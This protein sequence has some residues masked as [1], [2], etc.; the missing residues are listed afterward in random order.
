MPLASTVRVDAHE[1]SLVTDAGRRI[2]A[3]TGSPDGSSDRGHLSACSSILD[4]SGR[5]SCSSPAAPGASAAAS[6]SA[7]SPPG[8]D[9]GDLR[10]DRARARSPTADGR[11]RDLRRR[12]RARP[13]R[14]RRARRPRRR[15]SRPARRARQQRRRR[16]R[17]PTP[18]RRRPSSPQAIIELNLLAPLVF[19]QRANA[20]MQGQ[21]D[22]GSIVNIASVSGIAAVN[23]D[24]AAYGAAKA[25]LLNLTQTLAVEFAPKVRVNAVTRGPDPHRAGPPLLRRRGGHRRGRRDRSART[26]GPPV[27]HRATRASSSR[28]R[29]RPTSA[30]ANLLVHGGGERPAYLDAA[31]AD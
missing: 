13:R 11:H 21:D 26:H 6:P 5:R 19:A 22:G 14:G 18:P 4:M 1:R 10:P 20:V 23:P 25:G 30:G 15:A 2:G 31:T 24:A 7:S 27:R 3:A 29:S 9:G 12:R 8:A 28:R 17:R 16:R